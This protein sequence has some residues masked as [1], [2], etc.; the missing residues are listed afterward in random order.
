MTERAARADLTLEVE[1]DEASCASEAQSLER[2]L[3]PAVAPRAVS[4]N[5]ITHRLTVTDAA[6]PASRPAPRRWRDPYG[7]RSP[8]TRWS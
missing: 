2:I 1:L 5:P 4:V 8:A 3:R 7:A 6:Q